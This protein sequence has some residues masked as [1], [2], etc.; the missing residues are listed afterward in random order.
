MGH[1]ASKAAA[2]GRIAGGLA[3]AGFVS[4]NGARLTE[5]GGEERMTDSLGMLAI[6]T[7]AFVVSH[8]V[9]SATPVRAPLV[10]RF[11]PWP[12]RVVYSTIAMLLFGWMVA[13]F[14]AASR[15]ELWHPPAILRLA[16]A[17]VMPVAFFFVVAGMTSRNP[18]AVG[19]E[20]AIEAAPRGIIAVTRHPALWGILLWGIAHVLANGDA[21]GLV[22]FLGMIVLAAAGMAHMDARKKTE[23]GPAWDT[24]ATRTSTVPFA[25]A[26]A[27]RVR[28]VFAEIG[29]GRVALAL[30]LYGGFLYVHGLLFGVA[31][32]P[33]FSA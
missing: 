26:V 13:A 30:A 2:V 33:W 3:R 23:M 29:W 15:F 8:M 12:F 31:P 18:T 11:G 5:D 22:L 17:A 6:P 27:G 4:Y 24:F 28:I 21:R 9:L 10:A 1:A 19:Q 16:A 7:A 32:I 14:A 25:A 20:K